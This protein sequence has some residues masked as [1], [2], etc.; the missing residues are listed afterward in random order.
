MVDMKDINGQVVQSSQRSN[1]NDFLV[2]K[3]CRRNAGLPRQKNAAD[4]AV[5]E[6]NYDG[7]FLPPNFN[8]DFEG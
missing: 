3:N 4:F 7:N 1:S 5:D 8:V 2:F 6:F